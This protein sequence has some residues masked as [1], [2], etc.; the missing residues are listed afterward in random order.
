MPCKLP[1]PYICTSADPL[2]HTN[3][4]KHPFLQLALLVRAKT[5]L[6]KYKKNIKDRGAVLPALY[7]QRALRGTC[8]KG[9]LAKE[10]L[11]S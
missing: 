7:A 1:Y 3:R 9:V 11:L 6:L 2:C 8:D 10:A 4:T 5:A